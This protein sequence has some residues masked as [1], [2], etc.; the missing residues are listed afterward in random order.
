MRLKINTLEI[1]LF[2]GADDRSQ[3]DEIWSIV[4]NSYVIFPHI[5]NLL[6]V[7][8]VMLKLNCFHSVCGHTYCFVSGVIEA[9]HSVGIRALGTLE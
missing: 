9:F 3:L 2:M 4:I 6:N 1:L 8:L 7:S 5:I